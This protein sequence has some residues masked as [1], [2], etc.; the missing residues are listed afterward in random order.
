MLVQGSGDELPRSNLFKEHFG[1][2]LDEVPPPPP[3]P[4]SREAARQS[5]SSVVRAADREGASEVARDKDRV[6]VV[7]E[8][9]ENRTASGGSESGVDQDRLRSK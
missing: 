1:Q 3:P 9:K 4:N 6:H 2:L 5:L 8:G 7:A